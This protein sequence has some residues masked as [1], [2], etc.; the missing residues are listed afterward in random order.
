MSELSS[1]VAKYCNIH[2]L[3]INYFTRELNYSQILTRFNSE[4][5]VTDVIKNTRPFADKHRIRKKESNGHRR[6][7]IARL[8]CLDVTYDYRDVSI[9]RRE[10]EGSSSYAINSE[11]TDRPYGNYGGSIRD[12]F[13]HHRLVFVADHRDEKFD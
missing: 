3:F 2:P 13:N 12:I 9:R 11:C 7:S 1:L 4:H 8:A 6:R 5:Y 10:G